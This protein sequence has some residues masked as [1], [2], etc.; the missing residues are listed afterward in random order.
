MV[1]RRSALMQ[2]GGLGMGMNAALGRLL[3]ASPS[4]PSIRPRAKQ[5]LFLHQCGGPS[6]IDTF[7]MKP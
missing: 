3:A 5:I 1:S 2:I 7:D 4:S 6:H